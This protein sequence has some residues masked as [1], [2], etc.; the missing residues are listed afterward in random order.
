MGDRM[1]IRRRYEKRADSY[2]IT[3]RLEMDTDGFTYRKWGGIQRCKP[4]DW[5]VDN[6]GDIYTVD[7]EF[8]LKAYRKVGPRAYAETSPVWAEGGTCKIPQNRA[9]S[10]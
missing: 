8:F 4:S 9:H 7:G 1:A 3:V 2:V 10:K 5:L 6:N